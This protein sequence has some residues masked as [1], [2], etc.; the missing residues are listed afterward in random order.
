M[1]HT[2]VDLLGAKPAMQVGRWSDELPASV[3][4]DVVVVGAGAAGLAAANAATFHGRE[5]IVLG[6]GEEPGGTITKGGGGFMV[7]A[8]RFHREAG[9]I[10]DRELTLRLLARTSF[11]ERYDPTAERLGLEELD[12]DLIATF[13]DRSNEVVE[14]L[15]AD[16]VLTLTPLYAVSGD[17]RGLPSYYTQLE[18]ETIYHG[19]TLGT[20]TPDGTS[21]FGRELIRQLLAGAERKGARMLM[22][23]RVSEILCDGDDEVAGVVA[24]SATGTPGT[25]T[26][27]ARHGV[28]FATGGFAQNRRLVEKHLP[29][30]VPGSCALATSQGDFIALTRHMDVELAHMDCAWWGEVPVEV[31]LESPEV[32][33]LVFCPFGDSMIYVDAAGRRVVNEKAN[34][35]QRGPVHFVRD[36][37]GRQP[38]R[39]LFM[40]YDHAVARE[41]HDDFLN[42]WP[43]PPAGDHAPY[44]IEAPTLD[45]LGTAIRRR[46]DAIAPHVGDLQLAPGFGDELRRTIAKFNRYAE[47]GFD[48]E[49]RRGEEPVQVDCSGPPRPGAHPNPTMFP[50]SGHGPYY[51]IRWRRAAWTPR[52]GR[53][54]TPARRCCA[55]TARRSHGSTAPATASPRRRARRTGRGARQS[56]WA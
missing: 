53:A 24:E 34:Y 30:F 39:V 44:V 11:P 54:S 2:G 4:T 25:C 40:I 35:D 17:P 5:V 51:C 38:N 6:A 42:R 28:I 47:R 26:F 33:L 50:I 13:Y 48:P 37:D 21:G 1:S 3:E 19:R 32:P 27:V 41:P 31:A 55:P 52:V 20:L 45:D 9:I 46:L 12:Y 16:G 14:A 36:E 29:G 10:E 49:F 43:V 18:E 7:A 8:N 22:G 56:D 15:E 23:Q